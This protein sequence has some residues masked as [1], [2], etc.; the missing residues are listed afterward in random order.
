MN[1]VNA[2]VITGFGTN[3]EEESAYALQQAGADTVTIC[4]FFDLISEKIFLPDYNYLLFPGGFLDGDDLGAA[5]SAAL[6]WQ[7]LTTKNGRPLRKQLDDFLAG[8]GIILGICN[9]FQLLVKLG[10]LPALHGE[11]YRR[12]VTLTYNDSGRY[13][14][15]WV[16][17]RANKKSPCVFTKNIEN[18]Y[19][20]VRHGEGKLVAQDEQTLTDIAANE[21]IA[22]QY[23]D[24]QTEKPTQQ[25]PFNPN[26]SPLAIAGL[27]NPSG[28]ILGL[29][30]HP[31]AYNDPTNHPC[32]TRMNDS[33]HIL[34]TTLLAGGIHHL[35]NN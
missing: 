2:L 8:G 5:Q 13:E 3:C 14:D 35:R 18:I 10:L 24:P 31:E 6:R 21:L 33:D 34:G 28:T 23:I 32:W 29:M 22:L 9:G 7:F 15:R 12:Q 4:Y 11:N 30:P 27:T 17:L 25:Y 16:W 1:S 19:L 20:P 26:G